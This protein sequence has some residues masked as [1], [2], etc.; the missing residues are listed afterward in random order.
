MSQPLFV[1]RPR[2]SLDTTVAAARDMGFDVVAEPISHV[3]AVAWQP[4][5]A[6]LFDDLLI[7]S[8]NAIRHSGKP[9]LQWQGRA[10]HV[11]GAA[12]AEAAGAAGLAIGE[13]GRGGLQNVLD[14]LAGRS[15]RLLRLCGEAHVPLAPPA[16]IG[17]ITRVVYRVDHRRLPPALAVALR[18][19]GTVLLHS[20]E[21]ATHFADECDRLRIA[22]G[23]LSIAA[24]GPRVAAAAGTG[25]A[26]IASAGAPT[27]AALLALARDMC[28]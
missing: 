25:W 8:A 9:L 24:I 4:P 19:G 16:G 7:G 6:D 17:L 1:L 10:A 3:E 14:A 2:P 5:P 26:R 27:D 11:V 20:A 13:V 22:R 23:G 12:T 18:G 28:Q 15:L 21:A